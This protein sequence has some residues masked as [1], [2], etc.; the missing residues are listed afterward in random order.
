[1]RNENLSLNSLSWVGPEHVFTSI[2]TNT[3][4]QERKKIYKTWF[5]PQR[6]VI[7]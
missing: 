5:L 7:Q 3:L 1:M 6:L 4:V 2:V